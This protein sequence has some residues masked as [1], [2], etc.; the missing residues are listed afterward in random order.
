MVTTLFSGLRKPPLTVPT[1]YV[2]VITILARNSV[3]IKLIPNIE[4]KRP[5]LS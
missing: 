4:I 1:P 3:P 2:V 5:R